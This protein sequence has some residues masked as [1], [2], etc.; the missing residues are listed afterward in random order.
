MSVFR[1]ITKGSVEEK[2]IEK[3]EKKLQLDALVIQQGRLVQQNK[4]L[5]REEILGMIRFGANAFFEG[6][7]AKEITDED[8]DN[9]LAVAEQDTSRFNDKLKQYQS[10]LK[11]SFEDLEKGGFNVEVINFGH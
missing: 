8:I 6:Q 10:Q 3:A 4:A 1:L 7:Q 5:S 2:I 9:I 11:F